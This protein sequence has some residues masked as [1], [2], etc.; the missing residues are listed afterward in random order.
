M[1]KG[2]ITSIVGAMGCG[3]TDRLV[4]LYQ[5]Y[6]KEGYDVAI[7]KPK[8]DTRSADDRVVSRS[9][10]SAPAVAID[11][12]D[13][14]YFLD[15]GYDTYDAIMID[16]IQFFGEEGAVDTLNSLA[17]LGIEVFVFGLDL[18]SEGK[19]FGK[20]GEI[21][22]H[23][24]QVLKLE[25]KCERCENPARV[26]NYNGNKDNDVKV[27]DIGEYEPLCINCYYM[28]EHN[29]EEKMVPE[30]LEKVVVEGDGFYAELVISRK[31]LELAGYTIEDVKDIED[32]EAL[33]NL[34]KDLGW[35]DEDVLGGESNE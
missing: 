19:V 29:L 10:R 31:D 3:K 13:D 35:T 12:L 2:S 9:M 5:S 17:L 33:N 23:S 22:A 21:L 25:G 26:T 8:R 7:F 18:T 34:M 16:E 1:N 15:E 28:D 11:L 4:R 6:V 14:I 20:V 32:S 30:D 27:G 24:H